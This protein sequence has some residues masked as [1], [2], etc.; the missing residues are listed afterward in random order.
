ML[1][2]VLDTS[3]PEGVEGTAVGGRAGRMSSSKRMAGGHSFLHPRDSGRLLCLVSRLMS[4]FIFLLVL[5]SGVVVEETKRVLLAVVELVLC[6]QV[7]H[8]SEGVGG[9]CDISHVAVYL[10]D[11]NITDR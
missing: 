2:A 8:S 7:P 5:S 10:A 1:V 4:G 3:A 9:R 11:Q 6:K